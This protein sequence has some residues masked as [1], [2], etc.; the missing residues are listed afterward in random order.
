MSPKK[1]YPVGIM[2]K[3]TTALVTVEEFR[4]MDDPPG[5]RLELHNG[6]VVRVRGLNIDTPSSKPTS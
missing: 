2:A 3:S 5:I 4:L 6:E 1:G